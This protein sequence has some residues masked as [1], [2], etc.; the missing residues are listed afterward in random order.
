MLKY[1]MQ[2][3]PI[4]LRHEPVSLLDVSGQIAG[5]TS[6]T[7][8]GGDGNDR[9]FVNHSPPGVATNFVNIE[10]VVQGAQE[11]VYIQNLYNAMLKRMAS[12][13]E[14]QRWLNV[15]HGPGGRAAVVAGIDRSPEARTLAAAAAA[16]VL[17][18]IAA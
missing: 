7:L 12:D 16:L 8:D 14:V 5:L 15:L 4:Q 1:L 6:L 13:T 10:V 18:L 3:I 11:S 17:E 9:L 2:E